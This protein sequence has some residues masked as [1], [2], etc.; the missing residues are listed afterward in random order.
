M[1]FSLDLVRDSVQSDVSNFLGRIEDQARALAELPLS[2]P[3]GPALEAIGIQC[4]GIAGTTSL[5]GLSAMSSSARLLEHLAEVGK[6]LVAEL[7]LMAARTRDLGGLYLDGA[8]AL[9]AM[10]AH[11]LAG[12]GQE[13]ARLS[14]QLNERIEVAQAGDLRPAPPPAAAAASRMPTTPSV[15]RRAVADPAEVP[16]ELAAIFREE[17]REALVTMRELVRAWLAA[18]G[19]A[20]TEPIE[21]LFHTLKGAAATV[22]LT[23]VAELAKTLQLRLAAAVDGDEPIDSDFIADIARDATWWFELAGV[24]DASLIA[25]G[26]SPLV[27]FRREAA[28]L[29]AE[30]TASPLD[31]SEAAR[32]L[33]LLKGSALVVGETRFADAVVAVEAML[34]NHLDL[35]TIGEALVGLI[36]S[37]DGPATP[38][39]APAAHPAPAVPAA[40]PPAID[41][42]LWEAFHQECQELLD[43]LDRG[44]LALDARAGK[45]ALAALFRQ[46]HTLKGSVN[47]IGLAGLGAIVH[48]VEDVLERLGDAAA[49]RIDKALVEALLEA[50]RLIKRGL[51]EAGRGELALDRRRLDGRLRA[52]AAPVGE[53]ASASLGSTP[54]AS[55]SV[56][57][58]SVGSVGSVG[59]AGSAGSAGDSGA[60]GLGDDGRRYVRVALDRLDALMNLAGELVIGRSRLV[61]RSSLLRAIQRDLGVGRQRLVDTVDRFSAEHEFANLDGRGRARP[62]ADK[63]E[64]GFSALELDRYDDVH[65]LARSLTELST[66]FREMDSELVRELRNFHEDADRLGAIVSSLQGEITRARMIPVDNLFARLRLPI[67]DAAERERKEVRVT[68]SGDDVALDKAIA[69]ALFAPLLHLVRNAVGHGLERP[70][71]RTA[72]GKA[73]VGTIHLAARQESGQIVL[74]IGDDGAGLDRA[75]LLAKGKALGLVGPEVTAEDPAVTELVFAAG[76]S[77]AAAVDAVAGRGVGG[78]VVKRAVDRLGG[79]VRV[80]PTAT[81]TTFVITLPMTLAITRAVIARAGDLQLAVP[82][83]FAQRIRDAADVALVESA[84]VRRIHEG[85]E[86]LTVTSLAQLLG[87]PAGRPAGYVVVRI[88]DDALA[89]EV[90]AVIGQEEIVVKP[91]GTVLDGHPLFA[92][93]TFRGTGELALILDVPGLVELAGGTRLAAAPAP[94]VAPTPEVATSAPVELMMSVAPGV[95][96]APGLRVL[97]IDDSVSVRKVA[98]RTLRGLG[99]EVTT[100]IDGV[101]GLDR[102]RAGGFDL[103]FTDLEMP[104]MHGYDLLREIR[105]VPAYAELPVVVVSS[106]SGQKH[107]DQARA[108]G[109]TDYLTKPFSP[110][111]LAA[112]LSKWGRR[113]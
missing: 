110:E 50:Q 52:L 42:E 34:A 5:V 39:T 35:V 33:H 94:V 48:D 31:R 112:V 80:K 62:A 64:A 104:R 85:E 77:T 29:L 51:V 67:R 30:L 65:I 107:Q 113:G 86:L 15:P 101:D 58:P 27:L 56:D 60:S 99:A 111:S 32:S 12:Q 47:T 7:E 20:T 38:A 78:N 63:L 108:L 81:G 4:H 102:L 49:P 25:R 23:E 70:E 97:F 40:P 14:A 24:P 54:G 109:A 95:S 89:L 17:A 10:L 28:R 55:A 71:V 45:P 74:E 106:R 66:D 79:S 88:G 59:S 46:Y 75:A 105:Y 61:E 82:L 16:A 11:E 8:A 100:A 44:I 9:R 87:Q 37:I 2:W 84:G 21:R 72:R 1:T 93:V 96:A 41:P 43:G 83:S 22:G 98:E 3:A 73:A 69:D 26:E 13:S 91:L 6:E 19:P 18:P 53:S 36:E 103:V 92:G 90:D 76:V 68:T 57:P